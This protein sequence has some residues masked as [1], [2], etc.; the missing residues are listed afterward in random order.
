MRDEKER[1]YDGYLA[2]AAQAG[3]RAA[4]AQLAGR[5]QPRF[6]AHAWRLLGDADLARDVAQEAWIEILRGLGA[7]DDAAAFPAWAMRIVTRRSAKAIGRRQ[8]HRATL[9]ALAREPAPPPLG[10]DGERRADHAAVLA[11]IE[12]LPS[13][14][15]AALG[16]FY[17]EE[18]R[19]AEIAVALDVPTGTVKTRLMHA[20]AMVRERL[21]GDDDAKHR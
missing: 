3:D 19:V 6:L 7:L 10:N 5:W 13:G 1:I 11:A 16:L 8:R 15:R 9:E 4:L 21:K 17:L 18:M 2:A 20:R 14:H 12:D